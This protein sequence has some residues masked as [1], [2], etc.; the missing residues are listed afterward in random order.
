MRLTKKKQEKKKH[1]NFRH[2]MNGIWMGVQNHR[3]RRG[4][5]LKIGPNRLS[6][7]DEKSWERFIDEHHQGD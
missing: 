6:K 7:N 3:T 1:R 2:F 4:K 5:L